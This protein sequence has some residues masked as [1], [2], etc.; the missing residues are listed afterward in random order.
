MWGIFLWKTVFY[1]LEMKK[2]CLPSALI[3]SMP[4]IGHLELGGSAYISHKEN[5]E[6]VIPSSLPEFYILQELTLNNLAAPH[7]CSSWSVLRP[8]YPKHFS[9]LKYHINISLSGEKCMQGVKTPLFKA[10]VKIPFWKG[11]WSAWRQPCS[12]LKLFLF[13]KIV[14]NAA[15]ACEEE[16]PERSS[17][18]VYSI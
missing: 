4:P 16:K 13:A 8:D 1:Y 15:S 7:V 10:S 9:L 2:M 5:S 3:L 17:V 14:I 11:N 6:K 18:Y 12:L